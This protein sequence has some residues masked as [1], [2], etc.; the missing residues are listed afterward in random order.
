MSKT[1]QIVIIDN[2]D[3]FTYNLNQIFEQHPFCNVVVV[4][5]E[6]LNIEDLEPYD[7]IVLSPGPDTPSAYPI[8]FEVIDLYQHTKPIL[9]VCLGHQT[10]A[11]YFGGK[12]INLE[13]PFHGEKT[14]LSFMD[15]KDVLFKGIADPCLVGLYHSWAV[16]KDTL[17]KELGIT[18]LSQQGVIMGI[19]H[20]YYPI[21]GI[22]FHPE[23]YMSNQG[24]QIIN[25][26]IEQ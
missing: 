18:A 25:N 7:Q 13:K 1:K 23:S 6:N 8:L 10:I 16:D 26:W 21:C 9:G 14:A 4:S 2:Q 17:P 22:Q 19:S 5:S 3:S 24:I 20:K 11:E 15:N 12:L